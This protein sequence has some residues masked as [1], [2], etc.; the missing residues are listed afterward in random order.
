MHIALLNLLLFWP[1]LCAGLILPGYLLSRII[2]SSARALS[3]FLG[4]AVIQLGLVLALD[5]LHVPLSLG[6][7]AT[8][9]TVLCTILLLIS[10]IFGS[11]TR[12]AIAPLNSI[13][14]R[15]CNWIWVVSPALA[16]GAVAVRATVNP[17][18]G[19]DNIFRW[20]FLA[21]QMLRTG[22]LS[23]YPPITAEDFNRYGWCDGIPPLVPVLNLWS[24]L[25]AHNSNSL[26]TTPTVILEAGLLFYAVWRLARE[27]FGPTAGWPATAALATSALAAWSLAMGQETGLLALTLVTTLLFLNN[28]G[29]DGGR[30]SLFWAGLAA[31]TGALSR[32][33]GLFWPI[34]GLGALAWK[35]QLRAGWKTFFVTA[36]LVATPWYLRNWTHTHNPLYPHSLGGLFPS[37]LVHL[38]SMDLFVE[39][40]AIHHNLALVPFAFAFLATTAG[41]LGLLSLCGYMRAQKTTRSIPIMGAVIVVILLWLWSVGQTAGGWVYSSRV[42]T[43]ALALASVGAAGY[44]SR[45][46]IRATYCLGTL[47]TI[48]SADAACRSFY[49]PD[50]PLVHPTAYFSGHWRD[51]DKITED[52][53][54][55]PQWGIIAHEAGASAILVDDPSFHA[56]FV[57]WKARPI[58]LFSPQISFLF[59]ENIP[60][61]A[62]LEN[63][64]LQKVRFLLL[65]RYNPVADDFDSRH[66]FLRELR[67]AHKPIFTLRDKE[68]YD[69]NFIDQ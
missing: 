59:D 3:A 20:D 19:W 67:G 43:P 58:P 21:R 24:Y 66:R 17:L 64:R 69:L 36:F 42:L 60:F 51:F 46:S 68:L 32:E 54:T 5:A 55:L 33:Y 12:T 44:L 25:S 13:L 61:S 49:L 7:I 4:S 56:I 8:G 1:L 6:S 37:N 45:L 18:S 29:R 48:L 35:G 16:L 34:L 30:A 38:E 27:L 2:P 22:T 23:Y 50:N 65:T 52:K 39:H 10:L 26:A 15:G 47:L 28:H 9:L 41:A 53:L 31:G 40:F 63:L 57:N 62:A 14:P 11:S